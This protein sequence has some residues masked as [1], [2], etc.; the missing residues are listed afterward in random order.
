MPEVIL[1]LPKRLKESLEREAERTAAT[2]EEVVIDIL[3]GWLDLDPSL[4]AEAHVE[5][6]EKYMAEA[7]GFLAKKDY[8]QASE[9]AWGAAAQAL[10]AIAEK[11]GKELRSHGELHKFASELA[12]ELKDGEFGRLWRSVVSLHQNF[13]ENWFV[14]EQVEEGVEDAKRLVEKLMKLL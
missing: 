12:K 3:S 4:K 6:C 14:D 1:S 2:V 7:E 13:Y 8:V 11:R 9:K 10:K 5:L